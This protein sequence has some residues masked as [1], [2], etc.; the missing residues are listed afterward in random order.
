MDFQW[1]SNLDP[2]MILLKTDYSSI[3]SKNSFISKELK[4][5]ETCIHRIKSFAYSKYF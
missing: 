3:Y 4:E 2:F 5:K 1:W